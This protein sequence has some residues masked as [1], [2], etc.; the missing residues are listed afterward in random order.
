MGALAVEQVAQRLEVSLDVLKGASRS[1]APR[2][3]T[4]RAT[5]DWSHRL[6]SETERTLLRRLSVFAGGWTLEAAEAACSGEGIEQ[7]EGELG[8][9]FGGALWRF[10]H[11]RGYISEGLG[12]LESVLASGGPRA[13]PP[14]MK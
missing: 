1:A 6:L 2:Q 10:W 12:W 7:D 4:L 13:T 11:A 14:R 9:R 3:Q 8:L 5:V